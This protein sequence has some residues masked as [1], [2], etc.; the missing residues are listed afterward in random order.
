MVRVEGDRPPAELEIAEAAD[1]AGGCP[2]A[3]LEFLPSVVSALALDPAEVR[4]FSRVE[5]PQRPEGLPRDPLPAV[6]PQEAVPMVPE[7]RVVLCR[8]THAWLYP[9]TFYSG[10]QLH[11]LALS[12]SSVNNQASHQVTFT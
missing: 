10:N 6:H 8:Y 9:I 5:R 3:T 11:F 4:Q 1:E 12:I 7:D 2:Y